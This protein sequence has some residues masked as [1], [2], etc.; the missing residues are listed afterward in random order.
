M[1]GFSI[2]T[3]TFAVVIT[4]AALWKYRSKRNRLRN[5]RHNL[6]RI[7]CYGREDVKIVLIETIE[8]WIKVSENVINHICESGMIGMDVEW[9]NNGKIALMQLALTNGMCLLVR[10]NRLK[11]IPDDLLRILQ[12]QKILKIGVGIQEDCAKI[13]IDYECTC[14]NWMDIRHLVRSR[15]QHCT[16]LGMAGI[17]QEVLSLTLD[18]DWRIRAGDWEEGFN[19]DGKLSPRQIEYASN[20]A[21]VALNVAIHLR[22]DDVDNRYWFW[23]LP[24]DSDSFQDIILGTKEICQFYAEKKFKYKPTSTKNVRNDRNTS[25]P[26]KIDPTRARHRNAIRKEPLYHNVRLEAPD[27]QQLCV[28][29]QKKAK[30][31]VLKGLGEYIENETAVRLKF[32]P[33][34]RPEG[35]A[36]DYYLADKCNQCVVCGKDESYL[37]KYIVPHEYRK[38]FPEVMRDHQ[39]HDV[40]LMCVHCHQRSN[41]H[42]LGNIDMYYLGIKYGCRLLCIKRLST[43]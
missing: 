13:L 24:N 3:V 10:L 4:G 37:R 42:D 40:L 43:H 6:Q 33:A 19:K 22:I 12:D 35:A 1:N 14:R 41:L 2:V 8:D 11:C 25:C 39:S 31:Y 5:N 26:R 20:D 29:D 18:K 16:K 7:L 30:W 34:G 17:A 9:Y 15:R 36:G 21:L 32:E 23:T 38:Y 28:T 27:G